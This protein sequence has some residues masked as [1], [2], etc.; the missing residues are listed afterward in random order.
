VIGEATLPS[1]STT[2]GIAAKRRKKRKKKGAGRTLGALPRFRLRKAY[3]ATGSEADL[4]RLARHT[5]GYGEQVAR[6]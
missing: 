6:P 5:V 1:G 3:G 2:F 4:K